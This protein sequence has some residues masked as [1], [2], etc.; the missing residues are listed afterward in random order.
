MTGL[1]LRDRFRA[2]PLDGAVQYFHPRSGTHLRIAGPRTRHVRKTA[3][4]VVMFGITNACNLSCSFC[5]RDERRDSRW[6]VGS[7]FEVLR[8]LSDAGM[9]EVAFGGG[10]PFV[11][12]GFPE[13]IAH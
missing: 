10:E 3:P 11:F 8:D 13:L 2:Y 5:S 12:P 1:G 9:L 6:T 7:A 4:R